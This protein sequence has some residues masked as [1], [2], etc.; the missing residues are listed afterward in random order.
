VCPTPACHTPSV[1]EANLLRALP[2]RASLFRPVS[3]LRFSPSC[4]PHPRRLAPSPLSSTL[5]WSLLSLFSSLSLD[6]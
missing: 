3:F 4:I 1:Y 2:P 5:L 6:N